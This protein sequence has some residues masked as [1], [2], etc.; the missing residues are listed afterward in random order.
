MHTM[1]DKRPVILERA[2]QLTGDRT[3][4]FLLALA[5]LVRLAAIVAFPS[6]HHPDEN[7]QLFE[8]AHRI[9]FGYG[10][11]PWEFREGIRSPV[12]PYLLAGLFW[13]GDRIAGGPEG[14]LLFTRAALA[15]VSLIAVAAVYRMG[16]RASPIHAVVAGLVAATW[17]ELVYFAGR[18]LTEA[19]A[20][21]FL[22]SALSFASML[23]AQIGFHRLVAVGFCLGLALMLRVHLAPGLLVAAVWLGGR[24]LRGRWLPMALGGLVPLLVFGAADWIYWGAPFS[25]FVAALRI[26]LVDGKAST[27]GVSPADF[28]FGQLVALWAGALPIMATLILMRL[29][30]SALWIAVAFAIIAIHMAIPHKEYRF[31]FPAF[32]C[33]ALVAAMGSA[34][35]IVRLRQPALVAGAAVLWI[36][37]SASLAFAPGFSDEWYDARDVIDAELT[38][39][40]DPDLCG[41][42]F[43]NHDWAST[44]G[45]TYLH[46]DVPLYA[47]ED[48]KETAQQST[49]AFNA[50]VLT[51]EF[52]DDFTPQYALQ[53]CSG[54]EDDDVCIMK[55][56][57]TCT[58]APDLEVNAMLRRLG[59]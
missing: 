32:A 21:T 9:A 11:V 13:L 42:L 10:V 30:A 25:S 52:L 31:V 35:L 59:E 1:V 27:F 4:L 56:E 5:L 47:L 43:Y 51:H 6:L 48:D 28:Y 23:P 46:R 24:D 2:R 18:P 41:V 33:L 38:L 26:D 57:G 15:A 22:L 40:H 55:R 16:K 45:Y 54:Q 53:D 34:D 37:T 36:A 17:F 44:G 39:A 14:Y 29:R 19:V 49:A 50:I 8:Q 3:L 58:P 12:L 7:F 20:T